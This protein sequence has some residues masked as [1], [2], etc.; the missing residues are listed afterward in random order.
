MRRSPPSCPGG[1]PPRLPLPR[2]SLHRLLIRCHAHRR[3]S[4]SASAE[5]SPPIRPRQGENTISIEAAENHAAGDQRRAVCARA[6][7]YS[8][9]RANGLGE[10][11]L[12][13]ASLVSPGVNVLKFPIASARIWDSAFGPM[14]IERKTNPPTSA[15]P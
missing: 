15:P 13:A 11:V 10:R 7:Q 9:V 1:A 3:A 2:D 14:A 8:Q 5:T 4:F 6:V 12:A